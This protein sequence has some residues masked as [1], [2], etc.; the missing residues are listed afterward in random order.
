M[1]RIDINI[2]FTIIN[3]L[4]L[5]VAMRI[6]LFKPVHKILAERQKV[7]DQTISDAETLKADAT[8]L[9]A[10]RRDSMSHVEMERSQILQDAKE[11]TIAEREKILSDAQAKAD[12]IILDST[13][14]AELKKKAILDEA[15]SKISEL[16]LD[17]T[18]KLMM[19]A[20][21]VS[22]KSLYDSFLEKAGDDRD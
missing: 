20:K 5:V 3:L 18:S 17:T 21:K 22:D 11:Q 9:E 1:L 10:Q 14:K 8:A 19:S 12:K 6:F 2:L 7:I 16:V 13:E 15:Q 4:I